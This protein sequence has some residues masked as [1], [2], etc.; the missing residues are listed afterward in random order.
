MIGKPFFFKGFELLFIVLLLLGVPALASA[1]PASSVTLKVVGP[2]RASEAD[3]FQKVLDAF[4]AATGIS[5]EYEGVPDVPTLLGPRVA[6]GSPPDLAIL[7]VAQGL[8]DYVTQGAV[9]P[10][11][12][13]APQLKANFAGGYIGMVTVNGHIYGVPT[14]ADVSNL[15][16]FNPVAMGTQ[17]PATWADFLSFSDKQAA[18]KKATVAGLGKDSWTLSVL[19]EAMYLGTNGSDKYNKLFAGQIPFNDASVEKTLQRIAVYYGDKYA[20]GGRTGALGTGLVD[21]TARVFGKSP[22]ADFVLAGS[23]EKGLVAGAVNKDV[24]D[25]KTIDYTVFPG[26]PIARGALVV[27]SDVAVVFV[28]SPEALKLAAYLGSAEGQSFFTKSGYTVTN[29][30]ADISSFSGLQARTAKLL[31]SSSDVVATSGALVANDFRNKLIDLVGAAILR[32]DKIKSQLDS[33]KKE[34]DAY[35]GN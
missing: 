33:F 21:G 26:D 35:F 12:D 25:G 4:K 30:N 24:V 34:A 13:L 29:K 31:T 22:D 11:D 28:K 23:W 7:P 2:W 9:V 16:W 3:A 10:L 18:K 5:V 19:F 14:R 15:L 17:A 8:R 27:Q 32:P 1:A 20:A 6:A